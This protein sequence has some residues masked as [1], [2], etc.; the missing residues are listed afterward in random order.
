MPL[1]PELAETSE[2]TALLG[3]VD[4]FLAYYES[5]QAFADWHERMAR[6]T[7]ELEELFN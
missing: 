4:A 7:R 5:G 1:P 6:S 2:E 3:D